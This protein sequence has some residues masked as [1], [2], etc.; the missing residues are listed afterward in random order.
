MMAEKKQTLI[1]ASASPRRQEYL[2]LLDIP[3]ICQAA[4][5]D[6]TLDPCQTPA[7]FAMELAER[8]AKAVAAQH[9]GCYVLGADT[10]V[11][12]GNR[13]LGKPKDDQDAFAMLQGL[14]GKKHEVITGLCVVA[15]DKTVHRDFRSTTV[16]M[17]QMTEKE[18][19][20]YVATGEPR[21]KAG[22]YAIQGKGAA[23]IERIEGCYFNVVGLPIH[24]TKQLLQK[25]GYFDETGKD[26][27]L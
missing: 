26:R 22:A 12:N 16:Q 11:V 21:D 1:L 10:I 14:Q 18:I 4:E 15:P 24:G 8:K 25:A 13:I 23:M 6:E 9:P 7:R 17:A 2:A 27:Q 3:Y 19:R 20:A 5:V